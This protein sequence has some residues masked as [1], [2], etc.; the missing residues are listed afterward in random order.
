MQKSNNSMKPWEIVLL[1]LG[2]PIWLSLGI[3]A[4]AVILSLYISLW[5][6]L[7][8]LWAVFGSLI[9]CA[10]GV[11]VSGIVFAFT[12]NGLTGVAIIGAGIVC[13]GFSIFAFYG[14]KAATKGILIPTKKF[15]VWIKNRF[16]KK[17]EA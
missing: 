6:V 16:I 2:S 9:G 15:A 14:C 5:S 12:V 8:S 10:F 13:A 17:E 1:A 11:V 7:I 4:V 3:A